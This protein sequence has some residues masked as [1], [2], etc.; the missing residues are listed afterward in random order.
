M[1]KAMWSALFQA[2]K[3]DPQ[4]DADAV[5]QYLLGMRYATAKE[6]NRTIS[7]QWP[8]TVRRPNRGMSMRNSTSP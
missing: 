4:G 1:I 2:N 6:Y 3:Q 7:R 5:A 8:G